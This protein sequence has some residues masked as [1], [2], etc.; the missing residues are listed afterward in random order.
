M[1][2]QAVKSI[3]VLAFPNILFKKQLKILA[4]LSYSL[5]FSLGWNWK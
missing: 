4:Q 3:P 5:T 2:S 1:Q